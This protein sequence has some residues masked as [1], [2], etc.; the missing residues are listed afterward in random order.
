MRY[1]APSH[2]LERGYTSL[3]V[4]GLVGA[5]YRMLD[6]WTSQGVLLR[7]DDRR[8]SG[9]PRRYSMSE[10]RV[11]AVVTQLAA[12]GATIPVLGH[13]AEVVRAMGVDEWRGLLLV[14]RSG[15]CERLGRPGMVAFDEAF[16]CVDL[17]RIEWSL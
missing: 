14:S 1:G 13:V 12:L 2:H 10:I 15:R 16:W 11:A 17:D 8:G 6:Y 7:L 3:Q 9:Y 4:C 5:S